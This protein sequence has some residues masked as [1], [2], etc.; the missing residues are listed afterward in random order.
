MR[1][2]EVSPEEIFETLTAYQ[3]A[4]VLDAAIQLDL[5]TAIAEGA[6]TVPAL[7]KRC[8]ASERGI[9]SLCDYLVVERFLT[10]EEAAYAPTNQ[11]AMFLDRRS[12]AYIGS[13]ATFLH[14]PHLRRAFEDV[15][16][17]VRKGGTVLEK[18]GLLAAENHTWVEFARAMAPVVGPQADGIANLFESLGLAPGRVLDIAAGH[19]KYGIA[20]G[21]RWP[22][23]QV[24]FQDWA[25]VL[26]V[27]EENAR[28]A[29]L[30]GRYR[31]L[32]GDALTVDLGGSYDTILVTNFLH[33]FDPPACVRFLKR[34]RSALNHGGRVVTVEFVVD[35]DRVSPARAARFTIPMLV[36]TPAGDTYTRTELEAMFCEA[37]FRQSEIRPL[38]GSHQHAIISYP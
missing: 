28:R 22:E 31:T 21:S 26:T 23:A 5:F 20:L 30:E 27:A 33:H 36:M 19:G 32:A 3:K 8:G 37:G 25:N 2:N 34:V 17:A 38:E 18:G 16:S 13:I 11:A 7:A 29:G 12:S 14:S 1:K 35:P 4:A 15:A 10:K 24:V 9:R 6:T